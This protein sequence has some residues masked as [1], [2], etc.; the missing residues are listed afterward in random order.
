[1][2]DAGVR[3]MGA[4]GGPIATLLDG[5]GDALVSLM[6]AL[7]EISTLLFN[8]LGEALKAIVPA[9]HELTPAFATLAHIVGTLL[10]A[11][12]KVLEPILSA[13]AKIVGTVLLNALKALEPI[14]PP[15]I[16]FFTDLSKILTDNLLSAFDALNPLIETLVKFSQDLLL[17]L[18]PLLPAILDL[19]NQALKGLVDILI[20]VTPHLIDIAEKALPPLIDAIIEVTPSL[21]EMIKAFT[22]LIPIIV[23]FAVKLINI[24]GPAISDLVKIVSDAWPFIAALF[25]DGFNILKDIVNLGMALLNGDWS[26]AFEALKQLGRDLW[27]GLGDIFDAGMF[28][29]VKLFF[30][31][32]ARIL[33]ALVNLP[34]QLFGS[35]KN[36]IG[37]FIA[38]LASGEG[39]AVIKTSNIV[40]RVRG[41]F[42]SSPAKE[43]PFSGRG[44]TT[45]SGQALMEDW[46]KGI[47]TGTPAVLKAVDQAMTATQ[48]TMDLQA[49]VA[50]DGF[51]SMGERISEALNGWTVQIDG[52]GLAS[53]VNKAN[54]RKERRG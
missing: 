52:N 35:G 42:P 40:G 45:F 13:V 12:I 2:F 16:K 21:I 49:T 9:I 31:L 44:Y 41:L 4:L 39:E 37:Q 30:D 32:P 36:A 19:V 33:G 46:A 17:A 26:A 20:A 27:T 1:L 23:D 10:S 43:G 22:E 25:R 24:V 11:A 50:S 48:G 14:L 15:I 54:Q 5:F 6:P 38:G 7:T 34:T 53:M 18:A 28:V 29:V 51:G 3:V 47:E 8:V